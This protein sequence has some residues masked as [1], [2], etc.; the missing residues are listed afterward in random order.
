MC[1]SCGGGSSGG[2]GGDPGGNPGGDPGG[3]PGAPCTVTTPAETFAAA[4]APHDGGSGLTTPWGYDRPANAA[5]K[6]PLVVNGCWDESGYFDE[7]VRKKYPAFYG[8]I[9]CDGESSG[10]AVAAT[11]DAAL[12]AGLRIDTDR[13]YLTGFSA[14]GSG[15]YPIAAGFLGKGRLFAGIV[16]VAGASQSRL[17][18]GAVARTSVWYHI[19][20]DDDANRVQVA[21]DAWAFEKAHPANAGAVESSYTDTVTAGG[22]PRARTTRVLTKG[23]VQ[24]FK[25][26]EI[27]GWGHDPAAAYADR[28]V[29]DW[30]FAQSLACRR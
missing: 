25:L 14:G 17:A 26:S 28:T 9:G 7:A 15:S 24:L 18:E 5:R 10:A 13:I 27:T 23:G 19:G 8:K 20:L 16:R 1:L 21:R 3:N 12:A 30:L 29:F 11:V 2:T 6:Y 22:A 4:D